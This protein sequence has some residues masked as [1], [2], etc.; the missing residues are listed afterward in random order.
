[1]KDLKAGIYKHFKGEYFLVLGIA[2]HS[3]TEEH[4]VV[5]VP[6]IPRVG[7][8]ITIRPYKMFFDNVNRHGK[9][10]KRFTYI[11]P[12]MPKKLAVEPKNV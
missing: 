1:M 9:V 11:G 3:E 2:R 7:P 8:R 4:F 10:Q 5:Y 6:L 12:E